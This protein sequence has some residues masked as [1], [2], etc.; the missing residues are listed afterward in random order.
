MAS[1]VEASRAA[2]V[3]KHNTPARYSRVQTPP[4]P[5]WCRGL[6]FALVH[7]LARRMDVVWSMVLH[8]R[9][10]RAA[11]DARVRLVMPGRWMDVIGAD[12]V[13]GSISADGAHRG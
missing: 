11:G 5:T 1:R 8:E 10:T 12:A 3:A 4:G 6:V 7:D 2:P 13:I 9:S